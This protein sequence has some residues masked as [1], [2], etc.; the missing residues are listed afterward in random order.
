MYSYG[1]TRVNIWIW[2]K[3]EQINYGLSENWWVKYADICRKWGTSFILPWKTSR[4]CLIKALS[5]DKQ[6]IFLFF[7]FL[8]GL[9]PVWSF[10]R[11]QGFCSR[12]TKTNLITAVTQKQKYF[13]VNIFFFYWNSFLFFVLFFKTSI[14]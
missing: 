3:K 8:L 10:E 1:D 4:C 5:P 6:H 7:F 9:R 12:Q 14:G 2:N 13:L 11:L